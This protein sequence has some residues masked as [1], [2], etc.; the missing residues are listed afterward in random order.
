MK[1]SEQKKE[2]KRLYDIEYR[3]L[4]SEKRKVNRNKPEAKKAIKIRNE[5]WYLNNKEKANKQSKDYHK[6]NPMAHRKGAIA[7][8]GLTL[9]DYDKLFK[10]Q[11]GCCAICETHQ[12]EL[13]HSLSVDHNHETNKIRGLLCNNCNRSIGLLKDDIEVL[14]KA[15]VYLKT[16]THKS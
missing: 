13:K 15:I 2:E 1:T 14:E 10:E 3:K 6:A 11:N 5:R 8:Y 12:S 9:E 7:K 16:R 4:T